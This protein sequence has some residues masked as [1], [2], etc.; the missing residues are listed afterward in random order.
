VSSRGADFSVPSY[1]DENIEA[2]VTEKD[3]KAD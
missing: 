3:K 2:G 1:L